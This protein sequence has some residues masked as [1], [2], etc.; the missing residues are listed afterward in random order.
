MSTFRW[1]P[2]PIRNYCVHKSAEDDSNGQSVHLWACAEGSESQK[3]WLFERDTGYIRLGSNPQKCLIAQDELF[4]NSAP[5]VLWD[6]KEAT[7]ARKEWEMSPEGMIHPAKE[8]SVC[9]Q[10]TWGNLFSGNR[11]HLWECD[12]APPDQKVWTLGLP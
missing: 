3:R 6:C 8:K 11:L 1:Y 10:K 12:A 2:G 9:V 4:S 7:A 5:L